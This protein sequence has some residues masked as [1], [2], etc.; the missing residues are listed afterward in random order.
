M[1]T[2]DLS[3]GAL[4]N[5]HKREPEHVPGAFGGTTAGGAAW[6]R[7]QLLTHAAATIRR[8]ETKLALLRKRAGPASP[9][10]HQGSKPRPAGSGGGGGGGG[11]QGAQQGDCSPP[12]TPLRGPS[13]NPSSPPPPPQ[14]DRTEVARLRAELSSQRLT[15]QMLAASLRR[16][17][18]EVRTFLARAAASCSDLSGRCRRPLIGTLLAWRPPGAFAAA[19]VRGQ[20]EGGGGPAAAG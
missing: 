1:T 20:A 14:A 16:Q 9:Q 10:Q 15:A 18:E 11:K 2:L 8:P 12:S 3:G 13:S 4:A 6:R 5:P 17:L 19:A 7:A